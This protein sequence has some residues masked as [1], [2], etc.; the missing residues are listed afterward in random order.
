MQCYS[1]G[2][3]NDPA[4]WTTQIT[5]NATAAGISDPSSFIR[6]ILAVPGVDYPSYN[7]SQMTTALQGWKSAGASIWDTSYLAGENNQYTIADYATAINA[8]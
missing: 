6:P 4:E 5:E 8:V 3:G 1:G 7:P 2:A